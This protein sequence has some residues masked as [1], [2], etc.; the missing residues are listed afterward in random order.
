MRV[1][2]ASERG[3]P[4]HSR[5][6]RV[7]DHGAGRDFADLLATQAESVHERCERRGQHV[8]IGEVDVSGIAAGKWNSYTTKDCNPVK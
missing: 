1:Q 3:L 4:S 6:A 2:A 8:E 7:L 5:V